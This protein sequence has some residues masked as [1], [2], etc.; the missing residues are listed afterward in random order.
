MIGHGGT[1]SR[2]AASKKLTTQSWPSRK[3]SPKPL[4]VLL[5]PKMWRGTTKI[6]FRN[7]VPPLLR[8]TGAHPPL[9][10]SLRRLLCRKGKAT[11]RTHALNHAKHGLNQN[12]GTDPLNGSMKAN[13][14]AVRARLVAPVVGWASADEDGHGQIELGQMSSW[15]TFDRA[16]SVQRESTM[17]IDAKHRHT[18]PRVQIH[19]NLI[20]TYTHATQQ[21][22]IA[23]HI[24]NK[25]RGII[26]G[27]HTKHR[28]VPQETTARDHSKSHKRIQCKQSSHK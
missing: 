7:S 13:G 1:V 9:K 6:Y 11:E 4:I 28:K 2:I 20:P 19:A 27:G 12:A 26:A 8:R 24:N 16:T 17:L 15:M 22:H 3:R 21:H 23:N 5:E 10:N 18:I 14:G 25:S